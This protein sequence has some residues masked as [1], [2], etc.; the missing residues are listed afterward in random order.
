MA[1]QR[2]DVTLNPIGKDCIVKLDGVAVQNCRRV[3][4][5]ATVGELTTVELE[6]INVAVTVAGL[7]GNVVTRDVLAKLHDDGDGSTPIAETTG[8]DAT[9]RSYVAVRGD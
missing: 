8:L 9:V 5:S 7:S 6:L 1:M 3:T 4:V 2:V